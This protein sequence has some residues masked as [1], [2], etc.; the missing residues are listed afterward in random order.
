VIARGFTGQSWLTFRQALSLGG[1][2][3]KGERGTTVVYADRFVPSDE[4]RRA[5]ETGEEAQAIPF[6]KRFTVFNTD[7]CEG[8]PDEIATATPPPPP[9]LIEPTVEA[10]IKA[11]GITFRMGGDRAFYAPAEDYVQVPRSQAYFESIN[12]HCTALHELGHYA[13]SRIMPSN[14][15]VV[16]VQLRAFLAHRRGSE[17][18]AQP[19]CQWPRRRA[20]NA[21]SYA[22]L[23]IRR[24]PPGIRRASTETRVDPAAGGN[25]PSR[26]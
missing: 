5:A 21:L 22:K 20:K 4:K 3:R 1:R 11:T 2:V 16:L 6:V 8:L 13:E 7:Q 24:T 9:N 17:S 25:T 10:L 15:S 18:C 26:N 23:G 14:L 19:R 12:W